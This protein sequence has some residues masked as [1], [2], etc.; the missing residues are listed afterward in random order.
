MNV[1]ISAIPFYENKP[2]MPPFH[3]TEQDFS[4]IQ[5]W[6]WINGIHTFC[7]ND[8][9]GMGIMSIPIDCV[10]CIESM[11][12]TDVTNAHYLKLFINTNQLV[13]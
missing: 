11:Q 12:H 6:C 1:Q 7:L 9:E 3:V 13:S 4:H 8:F 2:T 5:H 10:E